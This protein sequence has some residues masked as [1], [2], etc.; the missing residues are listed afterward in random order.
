[1]CSK[2]PVICSIATRTIMEKIKSTVSQSIH[3]M[4]SPIEGRSFNAA[5][6]PIDVNVVK[7]AAIVR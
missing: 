5:K 3:V 7:I 1:M 2:K 6:I 4:I